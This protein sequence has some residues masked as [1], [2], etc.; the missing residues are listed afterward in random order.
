MLLSKLGHALSGH[1]WRANGIRLQ[2]SHHDKAA[3][4]RS[5]IMPTPLPKVLRINLR[6]ADGS[7]ANPVVA[8]GDR[9]LQ[10]QL[11]AQPGSEYAAPVHAPAS[12]E[13]L[14]IEH[15][16]SISHDALEL[17]IVITVDEQ[18]QSLVTP[19]LEDYRS[20][21]PEQIHKRIENAGVRGGAGIGFPVA[22]KIQL[23]KR[24]NARV[25]IINAVE[26]EPAISADEALCREY[27]EQLV[28]GAEILQYAALAER[29]VLAF[30]K[31]KPDALQALKEA[32]SNSSVELDLAPATYP[33]GNERQLVQRILGKEIPTVTFPADCGVLVFNASAAYNSYLAVCHGLPCVSR[34]VTLTG[35]A[36]R[37][38]KNFEVPL[39]TPASHLLALSGADSENDFGVIVGDPLTGQLLLERESGIEIGTR[40]L[41][42]VGEN[43]FPEPQP[44][45]ACTHCGE[46]REACAMGLHPD[47]LR[48]LTAG[49]EIPT[50]QRE[51][52]ADCLHCGACSYSCP[53]SINLAAELQS[54]A[55]TLSEQQVAATTSQYWKSRFEF[56][57]QR[58]QK[59]KPKP[60]PVTDSAVK[61]PH[62]PVSAETATPHPTSATLEQTPAASLTAPASDADQAPFSKERAQ[63]DIAAAVARV[64][65]KRSPRRSQRQPARQDDG[66]QNVSVEQSAGATDDGE[67]DGE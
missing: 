51:G 63:L 61:H 54:A 9:V 10:Y 2:D 38:P 35:Q 37:T 22:S 66:Q 48:Q 11:I 4:L 12:G 15:S 49:D 27:A 24:P 50:L 19:A 53:S 25:V 47:V 56:H 30:Q 21:N 60:D 5:R 41:I 28:T 39:G 58:L 40:C 13:I 59:N 14:A 57:Q 55:I 18:Q 17:N 7:F 23:G 43:E 31:G 36:L 62:E 44:E 64:K 52:L 33:A 26:C 20:E 34:I 6:Q 65:A 1:K 32:L 29:C 42:A 45:S 46:C 67:T 16:Q 3:S 8:V